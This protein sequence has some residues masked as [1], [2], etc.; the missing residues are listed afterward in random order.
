LFV[1]FGAVKQEFWINEHKNKLETMGVR[2]VIGSGGTFEFVAGSIR[3][4]PILL[5]KIGMEGVYRMIQEPNLIRLK[6]LLLSFEIFK[7]IWSKS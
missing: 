5:Q 6:R 4:A 2:W 1:G 7:Y 3:R